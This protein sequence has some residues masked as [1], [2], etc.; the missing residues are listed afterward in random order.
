MEQNIG[1]GYK[2]VQKTGH[3]VSVGSGLTAQ[4]RSAFGIESGLTYLGQLFED[5]VYK[6]NNRVTLTQDSNAQ[7]A[8]DARGRLAVSNN[9]LTTPA[10]SAQNY[11]LSFHSALQ[12]MVTR[13]LSLNLRFEYEYDNAVL[14]RAARADQRVT[15]SLGYSF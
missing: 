11:K 12:G 1:I 9:Q 6:I 8:P 4:Y 3:T 14:D 2:L 7:Y 10:G 5:Y 15:S 13:S